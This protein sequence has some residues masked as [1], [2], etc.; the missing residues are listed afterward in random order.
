MKAD[1][2]IKQQ[3]EQEEVLEQEDLFQVAS[4]SEIN[5][6]TSYIEKVFQERILWNL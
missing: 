2:T 6:V 3:E 1:K 4:Q 5:T